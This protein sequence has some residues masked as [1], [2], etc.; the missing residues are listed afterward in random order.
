[1]T[2]AN[3]DADLVAY[4]V[5]ATCNSTEEGVLD[6]ALLRCDK[7]MQDIIDATDATQ[8]RAFLTGKK[9]FRKLINPEYK[10]NRKD[11]VPPIYL[12][13]CRNYLIEHWNAEVTAIGEADDYLGLHQSKDSILCS[14]DKDLD[15]IPGLHYNWVRGDIYEISEIEAIRHF[16]RQLLIGDRSDN[17]FG[18][19]GVG[20]VKA[21]KL[22]DHL[23]TEQ[24]MLEVVKSLYEDNERLC[25]NM[26]CLWI[27]RDET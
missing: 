18:V 19:V 26:Q 3:I 13:E 15:M 7:T 5:A 25:M 17:I 21:S 12:K 22:L 2:I 9:N 24:E 11:T 8:Y 27:W 6:I 14:L 16:Y 1:M 23:E 4:R 20:K 10:A